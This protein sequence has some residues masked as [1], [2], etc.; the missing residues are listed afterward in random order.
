VISYS[1][2]SAAGTGRETAVAVEA[3]RSAEFPILE[4]DPERAALIEPSAHL[5]APSTDEVDVP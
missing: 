5:C 4:F 3:L 1:S 2:S